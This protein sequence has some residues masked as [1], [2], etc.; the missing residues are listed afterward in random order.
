MMSV[1]PVVGLFAY[2]DFDT[3]AGGFAR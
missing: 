3:N 1:V 2:I